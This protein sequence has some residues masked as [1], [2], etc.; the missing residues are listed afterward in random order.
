MLKKL[1]EVFIGCARA[2]NLGFGGGPAMIPLIQRE[3]VTRYKWLTDEEFADALAIGNSLPGP[4]AT[5]L[6]SYMGYRVAGWPGALA[7]LLGTLLSTFA[8]VILGDL[9]IR[10]SHTP[11][12]SAALMAVRP[13]VVVLIAQ[14]AYDLG[15]NAFP[16]K[17]RSTWAIAVIALA[18]IFMTNIHPGIL[19]ISAMAFGY[20][21]YGR[22]KD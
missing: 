17:Y 9:L 3:A 22:K 18:I 13:V 6:A 1:W 14:S 4:I 8:V 19:V 7:G 5:K 11:A 10:Y 21:A 20:F 2:T 16:K 12:L 15:K